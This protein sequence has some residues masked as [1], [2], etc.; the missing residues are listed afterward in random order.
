MFFAETGGV[1][2][3]VSWKMFETIYA[4]VYYNTQ[5]LILNYK[6]DTQVNDLKK[7]REQIW[8]FLKKKYE[9]N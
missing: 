2:I 7:A 4:V 5:E 8:D 6:I 3:W 9:K 1:Y